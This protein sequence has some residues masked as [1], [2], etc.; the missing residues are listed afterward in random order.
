MPDS[1]LH[2]LHDLA[3]ARSPAL[4][5][6]GNQA[7]LHTGARRHALLNV[8]R[9]ASE[10]IIDALMCRETPPSTM[11]ADSAGV[12]DRHLDL[13]TYLPGDILTKVDRASMA[14]GL[15]VR[16]PWLEPSLVQWAL[17]L[18][19]RSIGEPGSKQLARDLFQRRFGA[20]LAGRPKQGFSI[21]LA[22]W[23]RGPLSPML[24]EHL[25]RPAVESRGLVHHGP[26]GVLIDRLREGRDSAARPVWAVLM[27]QMWAA[28][29]DGRC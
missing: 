26:V 11:E 20:Q 27:L 5:R 2:P 19:E 8:R 13:R 4:S 12:D 23:L 28:A 24:E 21:P 25:N 22:Q 1:L 16:T 3:N 6:V 9:Y 15:E 18:G 29:Q 7:A 14:S 17:S 10:S